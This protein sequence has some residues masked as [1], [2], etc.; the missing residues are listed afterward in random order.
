MVPFFWSQHYDLVFAYVGH[1]ERADDV[2]ICGSLE[3]RNAAA[4]YREDGRVT[5]VTT[6]SRDDVSL[7]VEVA[8]EQN[9]GDDEIVDLVR[10]AF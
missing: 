3:D 5:A 9:A 6:L 10:R 4:I 2:E 8:M 7:A 1:A